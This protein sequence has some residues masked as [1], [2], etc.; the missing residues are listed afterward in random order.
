MTLT[1]QRS[2]PRGLLG[3]LVAGAV[4]C[5]TP[6]V[7]AQ[8]VTADSTAATVFRNV[9]LFDGERIVP[10]ATVVIEGNRITRVLEDGGPADVRDGANIV[11]GS[12]R[13]LLPGFIDAH[14][15]TFSRAY[16]KIA[17]GFGVTTQ[18][19]MF[20]ALEVMNELKD[21]QAR[22]RARDR[23]DLMSAGILVT[24][25]GGHGTQFGIPIPT[26]DRAEDARAFVDARLA[27]GSDYI[28]IV[29]EDGS[30]FGMSTPSLDAAR[31]AAAVQAAHARGRLAVAHVGSADAALLALEA[32]VDG[33]VH[34]FADRGPAPDLGRLAA[35]RGAFVVPTLSVI[36]GTAGGLGGA[37]VVGDP[38]LN[39]FMTPV[40]LQNLEWTFPGLPNNT[41][42]MEHAFAAVR[43]LH[44]AGVPLLAGSDAPNPGTYMGVT[45]HR[46]L[47]LLVQAGLTP[48]EALRA[49]TSA[50]A[51]A[52]M[53][54]D[55]GRIRAGLRADLVLVDGDPTT[56]ILDSRQLV[57][58][59]KE[60]RRWKLEL[61]LVDVVRQRAEAGVPVGPPDAV[62]P[63]VVLGAFEDDYSNRFTI[64][65]DA[66]VMGGSARYAVMRWDRVGRFVVLQNAAGNA[67]DAGLWTRIDWT[68]LDDMDPWTWAFCMSAYDALTPEAAVAATGADRGD[69]R[70]GCNGFPFSRMKP[71]PR[72]G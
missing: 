71:D 49:A 9:R 61:G 63:E 39:R 28:K 70:T 68:E 12:G 50:P 14:T 34:V 62:P 41:Q 45:I 65:P 5:L 10:V 35:E 55:R 57:G 7:S 24:A 72:G 31:V 18:F 69:L 51:D 58:V 42:S 16:I 6:P 48:L 33:L 11:D 3:V 15:H 66:W 22:G 23:A 20:T 25:A 37:A 60:G 53:M 36:E 19:D 8:V 43:L 1:S 32:G 30:A 47:E 29:I 26:L 44:A 17:T 21:E 40:G 27:E 54:A 67:T 4:V 2:E 38:R 56:D 13:T 52:F 46:E 64:T 59:W